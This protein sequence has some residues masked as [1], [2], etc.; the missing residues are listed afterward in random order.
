MVV[1]K[2]GVLVLA[3]GLGLGVVGC[4]GDSGPVDAPGPE[5][6]NQ[7]LVAD[8]TVTSKP[9]KVNVQVRVAATPA[10]VVLT[11]A[12]GAVIGD[13]RVWELGPRSYQVSV[14]LPRSWTP[15][16][17]TAKLVAAGGMQPDLAR[18]LLDL[19]GA[20]V[21]ASF[22]VVIAPNNALD[23]RDQTLRSW[24]YK[25]TI[26][27]LATDELPA[28]VVV[29]E[30]DGG[31]PGAILGKVAVTSSPKVSLGVDLTRFLGPVETLW[32]GMS[33]DLA[34]IGTF[35]PED[36]P[37]LGDGAVPL[38]TAIQVTNEAC[39]GPRTKFC[40]PARPHVIP[41]ASTR[42]RPPRGSR[43]CAASR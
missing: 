31:E 28:W 8:Q 42:T 32:V 25:V 13:E 38:M 17:L 30:D 9:P 1:I 34:P 39:G 7:I 20:P 21:V 6:P 19:A 33:R 18:P 15:A 26:A 40:D 14:A 43:T 22:Q 4:E 16:T 2:A 3:L 35:G 5:E 24:G 12:A 29:Y 27:N 23:V 37:M 10:Y 11:D 41:S 36:P